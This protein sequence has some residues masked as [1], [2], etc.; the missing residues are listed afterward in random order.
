MRFLIDTPQ[1][2]PRRTWATSAVRPV[3]PGRCS[4]SPSKPPT[5]AS[6][7]GIAAVSRMQR[8]TGATF[9]TVWPVISLSPV[10]ITLRRRISTGSSPQAAANLS[11]WPSWAK[12]A[13]TT[14]KPR[15]APHGG[16]LVR[17]AQPSTTA[18]VHTYGPCVCV[19]ALMST[20]DDVEA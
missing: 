2:T 8:S 7:S 17:T 10:R 4:T 15:M 1:P 12:Q 3:P 14:P 20:A 6:G 19:T 11:I 13:C 16:L 5:G 9:S 18:F